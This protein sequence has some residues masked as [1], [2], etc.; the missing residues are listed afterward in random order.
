MRA[1]GQYEI[2]LV[3]Q[4]L[5]GQPCL[6]WRDVGV[7]LHADEQGA[8]G[9]RGLRP[10]GG[11]R[12]TDLDVREA[13]FLHQASRDGFRHDAATGIAG[14]HE[15]NSHRGHTSPIRSGTLSRS[16]ADGIAPGR[17]TRGCRPMQSTTVEG[18]EGTRRPPSRTRSVPRMIASL[19]CCSISPA[20][21]AAAT[22]G[23]LALVDVSGAPWASSN[24]ANAACEV[25]RT[26]MPPSGPR[27]RAGRRRSAPGSTS[28]S[29]PG[30]WRAAS[31]AA[32]PVSLRSS[33]VTISLDATRMR[34]GLPGGRDLS[35]TSAETD[36]A[37]VAPPK[38]YTV[39]VGYASTRPSRRC[40]KVPASEAS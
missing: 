11:A 2:I 18:A 4:F 40:C 30:Q 38:P 7:A 39:S 14:A 23:R 27:K 15:K 22:P 34:N 35:A 13:A 20:A 25:Q 19:H 37:S 17:M 8:I 26:A 5:R 3:Q 36:A 21:M 33:R 9:C 24:R 16:T 10:R 6:V 32:Y 29:G 31:R 12:T 1:H 28:V